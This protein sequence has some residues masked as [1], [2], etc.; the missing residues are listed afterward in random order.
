MGFGIII[1]VW[2]LSFPLSY[3]ILMGN[4]P[5]SQDSV[6]NFIFGIIIIANS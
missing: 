2:A 1:C 6:S 4:L 5:L 3:Y